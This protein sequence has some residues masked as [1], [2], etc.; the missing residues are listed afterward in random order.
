MTPAIHII[1]A[2][3]D[4]AI[5][6]TVMK[7]I[8]C[9]LPNR[10]DSVAAADVVLVPISWYSNFRFNSQLR[11]VNKPV[12]IMDFME[13]YGQKEGAHIF[14]RKDTSSG[15]D[16][17]LAHNEGHS[18]AKGFEDMH[19]WARA[20]DVR[21]QF[22]RELMEADRSEQFQPI[23][24]PCYLSAWE[25]EDKANF[26]RR[27]FEVMFNW[28]MSNRVRPRLHSQIYNLMAE[29]KIDVIGHWDHIE[30]KIHEPHRKWLSIHTPH[31]H[32]IH[33]NDIVRRQAQSKM[34]VSLPGAGSI[35]FR[36]SEAP[37]H[38]IPVYLRD[39]MARSI[40]WKCGEN[41]LGVWTRDEM[42]LELD[43]HLLR[44]DLHSIY[45]AAQENID[46]YRVSRYVNEYI[47]PN[48]ERALS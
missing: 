20:A 45:V 47:M 41:C 5:D 40:P 8:L 29:G 44:D 46:R 15:W 11:A 22:V 3:A 7:N 19:G 25:I 38:S 39:G 23:E 2:D 14:G 30:A 34:T 26:D 4:G 37:V 35:C 9:H 28:G 21:L 16:Y 36:H 24:W 13:V 17:W 1:S 31:T 10:V 18:S 43:S 42:A 48:I 27:P 33:V 6:P 32:R 12:V